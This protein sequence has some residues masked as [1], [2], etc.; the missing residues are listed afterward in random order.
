LALSDS[1][2]QALHLSANRWSALGQI[3]SA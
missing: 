2:K 1:A 3:R